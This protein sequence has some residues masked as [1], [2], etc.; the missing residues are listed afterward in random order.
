MA[1]VV[2]GFSEAF[3]EPPTQ[4]QKDL[5]DCLESLT[6]QDFPGKIS[7][8]V[9][10]L[11]EFQDEAPDGFRSFLLVVCQETYRFSDVDL[12]ALMT[13]AKSCDILRTAD[14]FEDAKL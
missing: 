7:D 10:Q 2:P 3:T 1:K 9:K 13:I 5:A 11:K 14:R 8:L 4:F 12:S 6:E